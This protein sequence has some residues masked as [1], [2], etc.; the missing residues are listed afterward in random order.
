MRTWIAGP[1]PIRI[2]MGR[3]TNTPSLSKMLRDAATFFC[4]TTELPFGSETST[5]R[6]S[7][8]QER[9][10]NMARPITLCAGQWADLPLE[11]LC[12]QGQGLRLRRPGALLRR[13]S[14]R[15]RQGDGR[16]EL[17]QPATAN[18]GQARLEDVFAEQPPGGPGGSGS[19]RFAAQGDPAGV[20]LG[21]RRPGRRPRPGRRGNEEHAP[22]RRSKLGVGV[23]NGFTG[24]SIWHLL[25]SFPPVPQAMIDDGFKLLAERFQSDP[26][27]VRRVRREVRPG[28]PPD[29]DRLRP[30][31]G[32]AGAGSA[33]PPLR[34]SASTSIPA[35]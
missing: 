23:V 9:I 25:Y 12:A 17:R 30:V 31:H 6:N 4:K 20:R 2:P 22:G 10:M 5:S 7:T 28:S 29:G 21:R 15:R 13:Q 11:T 27:R 19:P 24:S 35:T 26:G 32:R 18:A 16:P 8:E 14:I 1:K 3:P 33:G 34:S